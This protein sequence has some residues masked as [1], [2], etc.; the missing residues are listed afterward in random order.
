MDPFKAME[1]TKNEAR[2]AYMYWI[3]PLEAITYR[4]VS[5][6][7]AIGNFHQQLEG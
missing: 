6:K 1:V 2:D 4:R 7:Y 3:S 5:W